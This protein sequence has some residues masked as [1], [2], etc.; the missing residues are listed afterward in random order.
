MILVTRISSAYNFI[1]V[2]SRFGYVSK[3]SGNSFLKTFFDSN[4]IF[5]FSFFCD[6]FYTRTQVIQPS[7]F[8]LPIKT[9]DVFHFYHIIE[10][11]GEYFLRNK[12]GVYKCWVLNPI[13]LASFSLQSRIFYI[14]F[15]PHE[16]I[17]DEENSEN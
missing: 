2:I 14:T 10:E 16:T 12:T 1:F 6:F 7:I 8:N 13:I 15:T 17:S 3:T 4:I 5:K 9:F 11:T